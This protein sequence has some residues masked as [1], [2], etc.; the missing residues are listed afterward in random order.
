[1]RSGRWALLLAL[2]AAPAFA[3]LYKEEKGPG[4]D[5][6]PI[7][8]P[9]A[10]PT[11]PRPIMSKDLLSIRDLHGVSISPDGTRI[12][13]VVGQAV[14][15][16][17]RYRSALFVVGTKPGSVPVALGGVGPPFWK[18]G[19]QWFPEPPQWSPD[20]RAVATRMKGDSGWQVWRWNPEGG[21]PVAITRCSAGCPELPLV[22]R[23]IQDH[24][25]DLPSPR[26]GGRSPDGR[27]RRALRP[28]L[29]GALGCEHVCNRGQA[30]R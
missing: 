29:P 28:G 6:T 16:T 9:A 14:L 23:R 22:R 24:L 21:K 3:Q 17:N 15:E 13:F 1:M 8:I 7:E 30:R 2:G 25:R 4:L 10:A 27:G 11:A 5:P 18:V 19:G 20:S 26:R 12:A